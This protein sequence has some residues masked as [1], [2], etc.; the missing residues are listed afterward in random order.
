MVNSSKFAIS[1]KRNR[2][3]PETLPAKNYS[4]HHLNAAGLLFGGNS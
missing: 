3:C 4:L 2:S 1:P